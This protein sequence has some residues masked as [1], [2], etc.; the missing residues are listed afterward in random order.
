M[1]MYITLNVY[2]MYT[3][4]TID[5]YLVHII[6]YTVLYTYIVDVSVQ[7]ATSKGFFEGL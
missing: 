7:S 2:Y 5:I 6:V 1:S 4:K 3:I